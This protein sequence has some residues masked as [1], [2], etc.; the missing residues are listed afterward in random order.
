MA[1]FDYQLLEQA[2]G[3]VTHLN[4]RLTQLVAEGFEPIMMTGTAPQVSILLRRAAGA[5]QSKQAV[6]AQATAAIPAAPAVAAPGQRVAPR[7]TE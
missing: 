6:P 5:S 3:R 2:G 1:Q 4:E 7:P